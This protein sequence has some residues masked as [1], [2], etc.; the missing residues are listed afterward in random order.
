MET[1]EQHLA[2]SLH[3]KHQLRTDF[4]EK[5][6]PTSLLPVRSYYGKNRRGESELLNKSH[7]FLPEAA[8]AQN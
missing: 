4:P 6:H 7:L 5:D 1:P 3:L 8:S 2:H